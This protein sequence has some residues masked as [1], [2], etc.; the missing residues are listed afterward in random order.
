MKEGELPV[1]EVQRLGYLARGA[2]QM[3]SLEVFGKTKMTI[4]AGISLCLY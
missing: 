4:I 1:T 2:T 3:G